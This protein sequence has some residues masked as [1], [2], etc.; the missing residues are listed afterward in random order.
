MKK[1]K[2]NVINL[3]HRYQ[4]SLAVV[5]DD[6]EKAKEIRKQ[7]RRDSKK[8]LNT[9]NRIIDLFVMPMDLLTTEN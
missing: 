3:L 1:L 9:Y 5:R 7:I 2:D 4:A 8:V 6:K